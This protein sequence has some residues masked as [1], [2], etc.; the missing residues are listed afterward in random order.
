VSEAPWDAVRGARELARIVREL[1]VEVAGRCVEALEA[2]G[3][4]LAA[5]SGLSLA[6]DDFLP[7]ADA[8]AAVEVAESESSRV[9]ADYFDGSITD[10][11]RYN[12]QVSAWLDASALAQRF[13]RSG[14]TARDPLAT[15][16]AAQREPVPPEVLRSM[17]GA[18][19]AS[20]A[21]DM[22]THMTGTLGTGLG[23]HEYFVRAAEARC[24]TLTTAERQHQASEM[25]ADLDAAIGD[26]EIVA[27]D[28]GTTRGVRI[29][30][31]A[32]DDAG[33]L[34][35]QIAGSVAAEDVRDRAGAV[36]VPAGT[37]LTPAL[38][39]H[40]EAAQ[41]AWVVVRDV[42]TCAAIGGVCSRCFGLSPEDALWTCV[43]DPVGARAAAAIAT[44]VS[45]Q[46]LS[47]NFF[48]C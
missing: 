11:E 25:L 13:V 2:L 31:T 6:L 4:H 18:I 37:P 44:A 42:R 14:A 15:Y 43:G 5:R 28:C 17:R 46:P 10:G 48:I 35:V 8:R 1:H 21:R 27:I 22:V 7:T 20:P 3:T 36:L 40:I 19:Q 29:Y 26:V 12:K 39:R 24:V 34:A 38:A 23:V 16:V 30:A 33:S 41:I 47:G 9:L 45:H 32:F